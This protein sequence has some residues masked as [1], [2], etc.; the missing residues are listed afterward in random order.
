MKVMLVQLMR[1]VQ[2]SNMLAKR[3]L[4]WN[5]CSNAQFANLSCLSHTNSL[6]L[7]MVSYMHMLSMIQ[8]QSI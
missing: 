4:L 2:L 7:Y 1:L 3:C 5:A 6:A 8:Q